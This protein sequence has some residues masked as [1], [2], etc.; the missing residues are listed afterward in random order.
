MGEIIF[1]PDSSKTSISRLRPSSLCLR[2]RESVRLPRGHLRGSA[3]PSGS[4]VGL[5]LSLTQGEEVR[6]GLWQR[7]VVR[8]DL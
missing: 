8:N 4:M 7:G 6:P 1:G 2:V 3:R 5:Q